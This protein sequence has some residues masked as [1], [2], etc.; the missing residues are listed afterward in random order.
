M[1]RVITQLFAR[2]TRFELPRGNSPQTLD[3][4]LILQDTIT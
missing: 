2:E 1:I 3:A 4:T